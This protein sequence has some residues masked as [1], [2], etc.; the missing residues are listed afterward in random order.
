MKMP[1]RR[2]A[3][4]IAAYARMC[5]LRGPGLGQ[6]TKMDQPDLPLGSGPGPVEGIHFAKKSSLEVN[7]SS[8]HLEKVQPSLADGITRLQVP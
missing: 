7:A 3:A 2:R 8:N 4:F 5:K 6:L 1:C